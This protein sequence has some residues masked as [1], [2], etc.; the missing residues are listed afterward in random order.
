MQAESQPTLKKLAKYITE[1]F[2]QE[3]FPCL[4]E[5]HMI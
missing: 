2:L 1:V 5:L 3:K 4:N